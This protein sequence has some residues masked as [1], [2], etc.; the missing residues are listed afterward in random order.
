MK[1]AEVE[2]GGVYEAK[3]SDRLAPVRL[4][5]ESPHGGWVAKNLA[6]GRV[7]RV[8]SAQ[9]LRRKLQ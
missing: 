8:R 4:L 6:T 1:K 3:V 9:R 2:V 5:S 7:V